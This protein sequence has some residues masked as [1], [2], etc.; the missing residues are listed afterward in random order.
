MT[1]GPAGST[2]FFV[3]DGRPLLICRYCRHV[4]WKE[5]P[6]EGELNDYYRAQYTGAHSQQNIQV[7]AR[8]YYRNHLQELAAAINRKPREAT[9]VDYG[10]SIPVLGH[11]AVKL[12]FKAVFGVDWAAALCRFGDHLRQ[13]MIGLWA[14]HQVDH[15]R[16]GFRLRVPVGA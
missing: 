7:Q 2:R 5:L 1:V 15:L 14:D 6:T 12:S 3:K 10:C 13:A 8:E 16:P 9:I 4:L 11:E